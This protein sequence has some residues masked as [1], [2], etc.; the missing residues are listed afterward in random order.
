M[1][2]TITFVVHVLIILQLIKYFLI[3]FSKLLCS[4]VHVVVIVL[5]YESEL[6]HVVF[7]R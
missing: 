1:L 2:F 4:Y 6:L 5:L 7:G 3:T